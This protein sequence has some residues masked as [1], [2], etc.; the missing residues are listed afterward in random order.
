MFLLIFFNLCVV[1]CNYSWCEDQCS[2]CVCLILVLVCGSMQYIMY[3][4]SFLG[5]QSVKIQ[6]VRICCDKHTD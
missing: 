4:M 1:V 5:L 6:S 2:V 3:F